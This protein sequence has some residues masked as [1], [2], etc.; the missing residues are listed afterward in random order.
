MPSS[1]RSRTQFPCRRTILQHHGVLL[2]K[3]KIP[4]DSMIIEK[5]EVRPGFEPGSMEVDFSK[6]TILTTIRTDL[7]VGTK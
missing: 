4:Y 5:I 2:I 7:A 3:K 1:L 6:S